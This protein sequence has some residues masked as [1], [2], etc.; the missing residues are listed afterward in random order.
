[1]VNISLHLDDE[2]TKNNKQLY[3]NRRP[4]PKKVA[5]FAVNVAKYDFAKETKQD[6]ERNEREPFYIIIHAS[7]KSYR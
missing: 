2:Q 3:I 7:S 5:E 6:S 4:Y 1:M